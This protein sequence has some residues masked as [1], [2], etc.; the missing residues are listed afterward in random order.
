MASVGIVVAV[1]AVICT[2]TIGGFFIY[3]YLKAK[4]SDQNIPMV[5]VIPQTQER[6]P[7]TK[8]NYASHDS[9]ASMLQPSNPSLQIPRSVK[10]KS[11]IKH[12]DSGSVYDTE[13]Y[14]SR[15]I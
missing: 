10:S 6:M 11:N 2:I 13:F 3:R 4:Q 8:P 9:R 5:S 12:T 1:I 15:A 14:V 7:N